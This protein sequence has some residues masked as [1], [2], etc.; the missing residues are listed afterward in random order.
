MLGVGDRIWSP[1]SF[2]AKSNLQSQRVQN[3]ALSALL[4]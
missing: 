3:S 4:A 2:P 1:L